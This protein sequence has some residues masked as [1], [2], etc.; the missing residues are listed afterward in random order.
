[1]SIIAIIKVILFTP[2]SYLMTFITYMIAPVLPLFVEYTDV[3]WA[4]EKRPMLKGWLKMFM[5]HDN[6]LDAGS[7]H[8]YW[9]VDWDSKWSVYWGRVKWIWRNPAWGFQFHILGHDIEMPF[10]KYM[11]ADEITNIIDT[12]GY[13]C[14][15]TKFRL[16]GIGFRFRV[17][18]KMFRWKKPN[19]F[20]DGRQRAMFCFSLI[21]DK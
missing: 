9:D 15:R 1:M 14:K 11:D 5:T 18:W 13:F 19:D 10:V 17:G 20:V 21:L 3:K 12:D 8:P 4:D 2:L 7:R 6:D 16:F